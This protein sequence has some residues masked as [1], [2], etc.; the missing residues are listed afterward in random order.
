MDLLYWWEKS[1]FNY[2]EVLGLPL[3]NKDKEEY[4]W[5][6]GDSLR[7]LLVLPFLISTVNENLHNHS[8]IRAW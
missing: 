1:F 4:A 7:C 3:H 6:S 8:L 2:D 5:N